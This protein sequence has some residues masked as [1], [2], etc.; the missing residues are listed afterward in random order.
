MIDSRYMASEAEPLP[1]VGPPP[2]TAGAAEP[3]EERVRRLEDA[4]ASMQDT[5]GL[6][7]RVVERLAERITRPPAR[8]ATG[9]LV[10]ASR[11]MLPAAVSLVQSPPQGAAGPA[12][13]P[14]GDAPSRWL[15][16]DVYDEVRTIIRMIFDRRYHCWS[17]RLIPVVALGLVLFSWIFIHGLLLVG[18]LIDRAFDV[19]VVFVASA[20]L[21]RKA[22]HYRAALAQ[23]PAW[24][25][26]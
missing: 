1:G 2:S 16:F 15:I 12:A 21:S 17:V 5:R 11:R 14:T 3:L 22:A 13:L 10:E 25:G 19:V 7:D 4:V 18:P 20:A 9:V 6:E 8:T 26:R 24:P 23:A